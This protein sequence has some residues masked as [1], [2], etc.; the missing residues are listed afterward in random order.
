MGRQAVRRND[1][2]D[3]SED[4]EERIGLTLRLLEDRMAEPCERYGLGPEDLNFEL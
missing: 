2:R 1:T 3:L 4:Q